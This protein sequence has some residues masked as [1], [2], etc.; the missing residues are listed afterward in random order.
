MDI[1][2]LLR[3]KAFIPV[4]GAA[5]LEEKLTFYTLVNSTRKI[6]TYALPTFILALTMLLTT[7]QAASFSEV[8]PYPTPAPTFHFP[9]NKQNESPM[10][11]NPTDS[12]NVIT[13]ANDET[14]E[15][16]CTLTTGGSSSCPFAR[17]IDT[18]GVYV[19]TDG[20][21]TWTHQILHWFS[22]VG[23]TSDGDPAVAIGPQPIVT[24][25][26]VNGFSYSK[27]ARAY[28]ASLASNPFG[29]PTQE[30]DAISHSDDKGA[31]WSIPVVTTSADNPVDFNDKVSIWVDPNPSS[32][33]FGT[34]YLAWTLFKGV[35][36]FGESNTFSPEP[37]V[38]AHSSDG[39]Q[40]F[41]KP[42]Q[43]T[44]AANNGRVGGRQGSTIRTGP[45]G[46]LYVF[47][48]GA[49]NKQ[50]AILGARS[51]DGG[52]SFPKPFLVSL[53]SDVPSP[54]PG[55]SFRTNSFPMADVDKI[56]GKI[57]VTWANYNFGTTS[58][59]AVVQLARSTDRGTTWS[60]AAIIADVNGRSPYYPAVAVNPS[61]S[62]KVFVGFNAIDDVPF[63][64]APGPGV[65]SYDAFFVVSKDS[66]ATFG[67][68]TKIS[69]TS[70]DPDGSST[71]S[72]RSQFL[73]DY[74]GASASSSTAWFSWTDSRNASPCS[75][76][77]DFRAGTAVKPNIY[78]TCPTNFGNT[79]IFVALVSW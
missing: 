62:S 12:N 17:I 4:A 56:T 48:D 64:T 55:A 50:S 2:A 1:R 41:S 39:G 79:D 61:D 25:G 31:T 3:A 22:Q 9:Q 40:T 14:E 34:V 65:V 70:S 45:D 38:V 58:G 59:H 63:G 46:T 24:N 47:W 69:A 8:N 37:I 13:G 16:D 11:V 23:L 75:S 49:V 60:P 57:Y 35:G 29:S 27:G 77:D 36:N 54:F 19:T 7:A 53:K 52:V 18:S 10:A 5:L 6:V 43:L 67:T 73:G 74:N 51:N 28:F 68:P 30:L 66:G 32:P 21:A 72:L 42:I 76:V 33:F 15:P 20:G 44:S 78:D 71:N 26:A